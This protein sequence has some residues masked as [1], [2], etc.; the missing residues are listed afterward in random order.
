MQARV[1]SEKLTTTGKYQQIQI[2][3]LMENNHLYNTYFEQECLEILFSSNYLIL[4]YLLAY[5]PQT[6]WQCC[7]NVHILCTHWEVYTVLRSSR[8]TC[9]MTCNVFSLYCL[10]REELFLHCHCSHRGHSCPILRNTRRG[11]TFKR[12]LG[13]VFVYST[14]P[15]QLFIQSRCAIFFC[16]RT[17]F[18]TGGSV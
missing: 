13:F 10:Y 17:S 11:V 8:T 1:T 5:S 2:W 16:P 18:F 12:K 4:A 6:I 9:T 7:C 15:D 14:K 3:Y